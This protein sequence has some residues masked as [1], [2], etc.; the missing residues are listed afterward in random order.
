MEKSDSMRKFGGKISAHNIIV[1]ALGFLESLNEK[2][3]QLAFSCIIVNIQAQKA[4]LPQERLDASQR[5][6]LASQF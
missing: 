4:L 3:Q 5:Q 6:A 2:K 1:L